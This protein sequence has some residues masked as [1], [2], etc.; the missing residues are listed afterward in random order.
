MIVNVPGNP[1]S[2][3]DNLN[4]AIDVIGAGLVT[5]RE[6]VSEYDRK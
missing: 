4:A 2:A 5:L 3:A 1:Q 6:G